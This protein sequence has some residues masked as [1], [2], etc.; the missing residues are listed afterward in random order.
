MIYASSSSINYETFLQQFFN[1]SS[2]HHIIFGNDLVQ[3]IEWHSFTI[4]FTH[5]ITTLFNKLFIT[6]HPS[7]SSSIQFMNNTFT[8]IS[9]QLMNHNTF[10]TISSQLMKQFMNNTFTTISSQLMKQFMNNTSTHFHKLHTSFNNLWNNL[11]NN[12]SS[13][14]SLQ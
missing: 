2:I 9:S 11:W 7:F 14:T 12:S 13:H 5:L 10:T 1:T 6:L 4:H 8:T 3:Q